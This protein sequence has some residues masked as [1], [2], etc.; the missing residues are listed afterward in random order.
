MFQ[1]ESVGGP[2]RRH[3]AGQADW[4]EIVSVHPLPCRVGLT[5]VPRQNQG[6]R[7]T[8][9]V[10]P[11][12]QQSFAGA[13]S[14]R[15]R[16]SGTTRFAT[17]LPNRAGTT[18]DDHTRPAMLTDPQL[19]G[20]RA[21]TGQQVLECIAAFPQY[22]LKVDEKH[23]T[24]GGDGPLEVQLS[25][26]CGLLGEFQSLTSK[27]H[28]ITNVLTLTSDLD[29][30]D[31]RRIPYVVPSSL[32]QRLTG[33]STRA[34][35]DSKTFTI[36]AEL[37]KPSQTLIVS[38]TSVPPAGGSWIEMLNMIPGKHSRCRRGEDT[39]A[40]CRCESLPGQ[41]HSARLCSG[42]ASISCPRSHS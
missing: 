41:E 8:A 33:R 26:Q 31:F 17:A 39:Q 14:R 28:D 27:S 18:D 42:S 36:I 9:S 29:F 19:I 24:G 32:T 11:D 3:E 25:V 2:S 5:S 4:R 34:L 13:G 30:V 16:D 1:R 35:R 10:F 21:P 15:H 22:T 37:T 6:S 12:I 23:V 20:R 38:I 40:E 7:L